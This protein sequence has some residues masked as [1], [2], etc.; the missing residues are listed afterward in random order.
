MDLHAC[1]RLHDDACSPVSVDVGAVL[2][3]ELVHALALHPSEKQKVQLALSMVIDVLN[4]YRRKSLRN[5][6]V[7]NWD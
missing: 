5:S 7:P 2:V 6:C 3:D 4:L 1:Y